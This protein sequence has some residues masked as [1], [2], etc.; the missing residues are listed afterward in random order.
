MVALFLD[1]LFSGQETLSNFSF[2]ATMKFMLA[3]IVLVT[4]ATFKGE[5]QSLCRHEYNYMWHMYYI[6]FLS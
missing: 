5:F 3:S 4:I 6:V 2:K 1:L